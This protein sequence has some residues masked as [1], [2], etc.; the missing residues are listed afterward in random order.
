MISPQRR[1]QL[2]TGQVRPTR[3]LE[4]TL[5]NLLTPVGKLYGLIQSRRRQLYRQNHLKIYRSKAHVIS[6]G[7]L[8]AGGTGKTPFTLWLAKY[9]QNQGKNVAIVSRGYGQQSKEPVTVV[10]DLKQIHCTP[11]YA[12]DEAYLLAKRLPGVAVLTGAKRRLT[13]AY[14]QDHFHSE[15]ILM[16]DAFQHL[17]VARDCNIVLLDCQYPFGNGY[18]LPAGPLREYPKALKAADLIILTRANNTQTI[19]QTKKRL[20]AQQLNQSIITAQHQPHGWQDHNTKEIYP[21][22]HLNA[23]PIIAFSALAD[24]E[25]F[26]NTL[27]SLAI[28]PL[29]HHAYPD[30][31]QWRSH[32]LDQL[33]KQAR[34]HN[35]KLVCTEKDASKIPQ[36]SIPHL[37]ILKIDIKIT[38]GE[39][40][41]K[42]KIT[43]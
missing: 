24:P 42:T 41:L 2:F 35:A 40:I 4:K 43:F 20:R 15:V 33:I 23:Q 37:F 21:L 39:E 36:N 9:L 18:I 30:H 10:S 8:T 12:S 13:I 11:P 7:N 16:D 14:A 5:F 26:P 6:I 28:T 19:H 27:K 3:W 29:Q 22:D 1:H 31:H 34:E 32:E 38:H 17:A 25:T